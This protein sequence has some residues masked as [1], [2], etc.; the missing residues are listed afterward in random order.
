L[1]LVMGNPAAARLN[2][3]GREWPLSGKSG[4]GVKLL[5]APD[6]VQEVAL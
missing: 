5:L 1:I 3:N 4:N 6:K 2:V